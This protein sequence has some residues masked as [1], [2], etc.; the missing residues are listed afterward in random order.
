MVTSSSNNFIC[1]AV[2]KLTVSNPGKSLKFPIYI[3]IYIYN[4]HTHIDCSL[5]CE[6]V[7]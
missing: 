3:Y 2:M 6:T 7:L 4:T 1:I 5:Y